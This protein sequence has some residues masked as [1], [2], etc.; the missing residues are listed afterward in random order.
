MSNTDKLREDVAYVRAVA[1]RSGAGQP[2]ATFVF[3]AAAAL[4]GFALVDFASD[5]RWIGWFWS[6][7]APLGVVLSAWLGIRHDR[8]VGQTDSWEGIRWVLHWLSFL[9]VGLLCSVLVATEQLTWSGYSSIWLLF[10]ALTFFLAGLH[11]DRRLLTVGLVAGV[12]YVI[13]LFVPDYGWT[14]TGVL[15]AAALLTLGYLGDNSRAQSS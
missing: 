8:R 4:I 15:F 3:W 6:V 9:G 12:G 11:L 1:Q 14:I 7:A 13:T 5:P 2:T 10:L